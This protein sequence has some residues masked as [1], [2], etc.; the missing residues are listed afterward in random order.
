MADRMSTEFE[1]TLA[2]LAREDRDPCRRTLG[3]AIDR[4]VSAA[5]EARGA[6]DGIEATGFALPARLDGAVRDAWK[7]AAALLTEAALLDG[8]DAAL[9]DLESGSPAVSPLEQ[10]RNFYGFAL[11]YPALAGAAGR[12]GEA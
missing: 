6:V 2:D 7:A 10:A 5:F 9:L 3:G 8:C 12:D 1:R 11:V 4:L